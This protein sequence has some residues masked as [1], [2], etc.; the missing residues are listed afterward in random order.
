ME[1]RQGHRGGEQEDGQNE[2]ESETKM[3]NET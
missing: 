2:S 3:D 1:K